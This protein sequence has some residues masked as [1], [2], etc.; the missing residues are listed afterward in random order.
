LTRPGPF[1]FTLSRDWF[2]QALPHFRKLMTDRLS[3]ENGTRSP[4]RLHRWPVSAYPWIK[5]DLDNDILGITW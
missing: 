4:L 1:R 2:L 5:Q 3:I